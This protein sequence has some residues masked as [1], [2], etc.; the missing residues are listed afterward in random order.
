MMVR[1]PHELM[2]IA[3]KACNAT[4]EFRTGISDYKDQP[5]SSS[6]SQNTLCGR[7]LRN[8]KETELTS[9]IWRASGLK[10]HLQNGGLKTRSFCSVF[11]ATVQTTKHIF[12]LKICV[13]HTWEHLWCFSIVLLKL[14]V[15]THAHIRQLTAFPAVTTDSNP[16]LNPFN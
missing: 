2:D 1:S 3:K 16:P 15:W 5:N 13:Q 7:S 8:W 6:G 9:S 12:L 14:G 4:Q 10:I 11:S